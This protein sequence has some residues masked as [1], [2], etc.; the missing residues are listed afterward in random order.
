MGVSR[1]VSFYYLCFNNSLLYC[2]IHY[3]INI[4]ESESEYSTA[5]TSI[6]TALPVPCGSPAVPSN[7]LPVV[8]DF[9]VGDSIVVTCKDGY[10]ATEDM[11]VSCQ[12]DRSWTK[13]QGRCECECFPTARSDQ[14]LLWHSIAKYVNRIN[15]IMRWK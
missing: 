5:A 13:P 3:Q 9:K 1:H 14:F 11:S 10:A 6:C 8:G 15:G 2:T 7:A 4:S 12:E